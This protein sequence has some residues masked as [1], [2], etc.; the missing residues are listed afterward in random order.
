MYTFL[1]IS[2]VVG[3]AVNPHPWIP[4]GPGD[5]RSPCPGLNALANHGILPRNGKGLTVPML[6]TALLQGYNVGNDFST[7]IGTAGLLSSPKLVKSSFDL[8]DLDQHNFPI[9]HDASLS[10]LDFYQGDDHSF[11][12]ATWQTVVAYTQGS[13]TFNISSAAHAKYN[14]VQ[15]QRKVNPTFSYGP[16]EFILSY[17]ETALY[18]SVMGDPVTGIAPVSYV[19]SFFESERLPYELGWTPPTTQTTLMT[20]GAMVLQLNAASGEAVPETLLVTS[21]TVP[22]LLKSAWSGLRLG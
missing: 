5:V 12:N 11:N 1:L 19:R 7:T 6:N 4:A 16:R 10:R 21:Q 22:S 13:E 14:R 17:G 2:L 20:L 18:L 15:T 3:A 8:N 9:E